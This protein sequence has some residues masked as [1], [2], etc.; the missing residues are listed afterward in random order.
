MYQDGVKVELPGNS[1]P[2]FGGTDTHF[3]ST[4]TGSSSSSSGSS[5]TSSSSS[6][7]GT[8][9]TTTTYTTPTDVDDKLQTESGSVFLNEPYKWLFLL[10]AVLISSQ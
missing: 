7:S 3:E 1:Q 8:T 9:T 10:M 4:Q 5:S 2:V 6:G